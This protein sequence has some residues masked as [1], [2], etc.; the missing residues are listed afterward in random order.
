MVSVN[1][2]LVKMANE[3]GKNTDI[4]TVSDLSD[5]DNLIQYCLQNKV[6]KTVIDKLLKR[7]FHSLDTLKYTDYLLI[8][9]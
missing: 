8:C 3:T 1:K 9:F 5:T 2:S 6:K 7:G 4:G